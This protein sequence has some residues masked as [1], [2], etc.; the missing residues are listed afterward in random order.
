MQIEHSRLI[1][2][3]CHTRI[4]ESISNIRNETNTTML[5]VKSKTCIF[6]ASSKRE[7]RK[8]HYKNMRVAA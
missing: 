2:A 5:A 1:F 7:N 4:G 8:L 3:T 6:E